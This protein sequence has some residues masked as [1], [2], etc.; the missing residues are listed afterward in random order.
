MSDEQANI[1]QPLGRP[2]MFPAALPSGL[3]T[4]VSVSGP[5][6]VGPNS[7]NLL[8][9][10]TVTNNVLELNPVNNFNVNSGV[11]PGNTKVSVRLSSTNKYVSSI[12]PNFANYIK[13]CVW[14]GRTIT[15]TSSIR[16]HIG[17]TMS[18]VQQLDDTFVGNPGN[19]SYTVTSG[20][21]P[22]NYSLQFSGFGVTHVFLTPL[23]ISARASNG[24]T[25]YI[26]FVS[27]W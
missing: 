6:Y 3:P 26:T 2:L 14:S 8:F 25:F 27:G 18:Q 12:G 21:P 17:A 7:I 19:V 23:T 4:V 24:Q 1:L 22:N 20:A 16:V 11:V 5:T 9:P 10:F 13:N 15:N